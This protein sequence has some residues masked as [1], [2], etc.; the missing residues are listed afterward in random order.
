MSENNI[1]PPANVAPAEP[2]QPVAEPAQPPKPFVEVPVPQSMSLIEATEA[3][4]KADVIHAAAPKTN[5]DV[6]TG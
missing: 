1:T 6:I 3:S 2:A 4:K 5:Q